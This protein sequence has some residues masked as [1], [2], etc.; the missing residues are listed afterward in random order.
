MNNKKDVSNT[1]SDPE[2]EVRD[3]EPA[4]EAKGGGGQKPA[5]GVGVGGGG[6]KIPVDPTT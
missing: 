4:K 1:D 6:I 5:S 3:L 2:N